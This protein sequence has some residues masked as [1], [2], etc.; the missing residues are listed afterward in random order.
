[1][2]RDKGRN[3]E[4]PGLLRASHSASALQQQHFACQ[5]RVPSYFLSRPHSKLKCSPPG[6]V[7]HFQPEGNNRLLFYNSRYI[8]YIIREV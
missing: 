4:W 8:F 1:M 6:A 5:S 7:A 3:G 2:T